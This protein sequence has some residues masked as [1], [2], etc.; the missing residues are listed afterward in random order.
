MNK[1]REAYR[2]ASEELPKYILSVEK[3]QD[4]L[5]HRRMRHQTQKYWVMR[6]SMAATVFLL[7]GAGTVAA[8]NYRDS[9]IRVNDTG[10][11]ITKQQN[12]DTSTQFLKIGGVFSTEDDIPEDAVIELLEPQIVEYDSFERFLAEGNVTVAALDEV[13][14]EEGFACERVLVMDQG[15]EVHIDLMN[16]QRSFSLLQLDYRDAVSYSS[17]ISYMGQSDNERNVINSQGLNYVVFDTL[18]ESGQIEA[19]HAVISLNGRDLAFTFRGFEE[20]EIETILENLDL[21]IYFQD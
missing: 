12:I 1:F 20:K 7:F 13:F 2:K 21:A 6:C 4:E 17:S 16:E 9:V 10:V 8:K 18:D 5:H 19:I 3:A 14:S 11:T 15:R